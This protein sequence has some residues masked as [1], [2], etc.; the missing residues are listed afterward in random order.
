MGYGQLDWRLRSDPRVTVLERTNARFLTCE[1]LPVPPSF[2]TADLSFISLTVALGPVLECARA[3]YRG[4]VLV[5]PQFEAGREHVGKGG[6]VRDPAVHR[7]CCGGSVSGWRGA[8]PPCSACVTQAIRVQRGTW[9][10]SSTSAT[11]PRPGRRLA[12]LPSGGRR[13][14]GG[15][16]WLSRLRRIA[17]LTHLLAGTHAEALRELA[18]LRER[19]GLELLVPAEEV[20][21]HPLARA[22]RVSARG[23]RGAA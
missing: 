15:C 3:G 1:R 10:T 18:A 8:A 5:K 11:P 13:R 19:L 9:S 17:V 6:V 2:V 12:S 7:R 16:P 22:A 21:K 14:G 23:R 4:L 20:A